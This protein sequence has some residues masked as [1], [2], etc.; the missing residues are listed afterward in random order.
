M[1]EEE[2]GQFLTSTVEDIG[3]KGFSI[4]NFP[5][6]EVKQNSYMKQNH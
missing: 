5:I 1:V 3:S 2:G 4:L 6:I